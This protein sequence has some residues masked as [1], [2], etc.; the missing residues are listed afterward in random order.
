M[1]TDGQNAPQFIMA[2]RAMYEIEQ[3]L[4]YGIFP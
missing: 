2:V 3:S 1:H 4:I